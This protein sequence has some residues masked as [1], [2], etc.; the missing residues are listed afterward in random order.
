MK[1]SIPYFNMSIR[2]LLKNRYRNS[3]VSKQLAETIDIVIPI[4]V[5][6]TAETFDNVF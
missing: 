2:A 3:H 4:Y 1:Q 6:R 5:N